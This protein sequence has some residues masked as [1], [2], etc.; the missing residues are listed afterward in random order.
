MTR[1]SRS[2]F[3]VV[4]GVSAVLAALAVGSPAGAK[5]AAPAA[6][7]AQHVLLLSVDGLHQSDL[8]WW[9][10][11]HPYGNIARLVRGGTQYEHASTPIPSDSFPGLVGQITGGNPA[12]T[13]IY[14]D[15][16][17]NRSLLPPGSSCTP[18]QTTGLG[19]EVNLA[20]NLDV[21]SN[22]IDAGFGIA[23]LYS[24]LPSSVLALPGD[25]PTI[26]QK[27]ID[28][29]QPADRPGHLQARLPAPVPEG[30]HDLRGRARGGAAHRLD[31]QACELRDR[32]R[33]ER[34]RRRRPLHARDQQLRDRSGL[35]AGPG[36]G[37]DG[38]QPGH[39]V[40]R[41][42]QGRLDHQ[43]DQRVRS[44][45]RDQGRNA[46]A[47]RHELPVGLDGREAADLAALRA[48]RERRLRAPA[49]RLGSRPRPAGR[50]RV[51]RRADRAHALPAEPPG[52]ARLDDGHPVG[53]ARTVA[54][55]DVLAE[56]H[57][58]RQDH[59]RGERRV[60]GA[61]RE[62][63]ADRVRDRRRR[64]VHLARRSIPGCRRVRA[65]LPAL[66]PPA[67][68]GECRD[69]LPGRPDRIQLLGPRAS[70]QRPRLLRA[71]RERRARPRPRRR[72]PARRRVH[73][74]DGQDRRARRRG[75]AGSPRAA[76]GLRRRRRPRRVRIASRRRRSRPRS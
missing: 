76:G 55:R 23:N 41:R 58:R 65:R 63:Q 8:T 34:H 49:R 64:H 33:P 32:R 5:E 6:G 7:P 36:R 27:M 1:R 69:G 19:S 20:E 62:R 47:L 25:V 52:T 28:R 59:R 43:R 10:H 18:G 72:R 74:R 70:L 21:D 60:D 57:Q 35:P 66:L 71:A 22:S 54:D 73:R 39:A 16:T 31:R 42:D 9:I 24:G 38:Q 37:L 14:Y 53:E 3:G 4:A 46:F 56:A 50:A 2:L 17:Y 45:R 11:D 15:D 67:G 68:V 13:G 40:L 75:R 12:T 51:R 61:R 44:Q 26:D 48:H 29:G 30:Q